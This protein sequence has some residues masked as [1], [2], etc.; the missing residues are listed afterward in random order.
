MVN[1]R[2]VA[3]HALEERLA[4]AGISDA[5]VA[6]K[7]RM[8]ARASTALGRRQTLRL[9]VPGRIEFL[10]KHTDYAGGRSLICTVERGFAVAAS[11]R[12]DRVVRVT[13]VESGE[14]AELELDPT[15]PSADGAWSNYAITVVRRIAKNFPG[16]LRGADIAFSS[17]LP[18]A[19]GLSSSSALVVATFLALS[20][21][22]ALAAHEEYRRAIS[23]AE[24]LA[25]YLGAIEAGTGFASLDGDRGVGTFSGSQDQTAILCSRAGALVQYAF[26]PVRFERTVALPSDHVF[27]IGASGVLAEK[28]GAALELYNRQARRVHAL[29]DRWRS[30]TGRSDATLGD[31]LASSGDALDRLRAIVRDPTVSAIGNDRFDVS[32]LISRLDQFATEADEIIPAAGDALEQGDLVALGEIVDRSERGAEEQLGNQVPETVH[33]ARSARALGAVA[34]SAFGA[35]FGGSVWT[36]VER[37]EAE[38]FLDCWQD[39]YASRFPEPA[40]RATFFVTSAGPAA[41]RL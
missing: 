20:D 3:A 40:K 19:A 21:L 2:D 14:H 5:E 28:T 38:R 29:L 31:V 41:M 24:E 12:D 34:A 33:L 36:L 35:G 25:G 39:S 23:N 26:A 10:G 7:S 6:R 18:P 16:P 17:D 27:V 4:L 9:W 22:N 30:A 8:F 15:L 13:D 1:V 11:A 32:D 37:S